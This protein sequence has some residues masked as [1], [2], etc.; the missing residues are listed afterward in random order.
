MRCSIEKHQQLVDAAKIEY[1]RL[2]EL[3]K[4]GYEEDLEN[5][6]LDIQEAMDNMRAVMQRKPEKIKI[7][8][9][10]GIKFVTGVVIVNNQL[11]PANKHCRDIRILKKINND[12]KATQSLMGKNNYLKQIANQ[13]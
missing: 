5:N 4:H 7:F 9:A 13:V 12:L 11:H 10:K 1:R 8:S 6:I 3:Q 2:V